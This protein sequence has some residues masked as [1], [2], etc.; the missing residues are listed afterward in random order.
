MGPMVKVGNGQRVRWWGSTA[1]VADVP[2][3]CEKSMIHIVLNSNSQNNQP[4]A[5]KSR[6]Y[7]DNNNKPF[8]QRFDHNAAV[9]I[10]ACTKTQIHN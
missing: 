3:I 8:C 2:V 9:F 5:I 7:N 6:V 4:V 10:R 1:C